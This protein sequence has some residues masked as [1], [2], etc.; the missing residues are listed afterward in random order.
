MTGMMM[1]GWLRPVRSFQFLYE[2]HVVRAVIQGLNITSMGLSEHFSWLKLAIRRGNWVQLVG[3]SV[4]KVLLLWSW[5]LLILTETAWVVE[6]GFKP[7][8]SSHNLDCFWSWISRRLNDSAPQIFSDSRTQQ[9]STRA[10][11]DCTWVVF[12]DRS[13]YVPN[14]M[15]LMIHLS[16]PSSRKSLSW[17]AICIIV[18]CSCYCSFVHRSLDEGIP[19]TV[20]QQLSGHESG[21]PFCFAVFLPSCGILNKVE[22]MV[23]AFGRTVHEKLAFGPSKGTPQHI[24]MQRAVLARAYEVLRFPSPP[25]YAIRYESGIWKPSIRRPTR[26]LPNWLES[27]Y[28]D[29]K[30]S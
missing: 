15:Q 26:H 6:C 17:L 13:N 19:C 3:V 22:E 11:L 14:F 7:L 30:A 16:Q 4:T 23:L 10:R 29:I 25:H 12:C 21:G 28:F 2:V 18:I 8:I 9:I 1:L 24:C 27:T 20:C 5:W